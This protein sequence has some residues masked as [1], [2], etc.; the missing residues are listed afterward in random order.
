M[1]QKQIEEIET[2][3]TVEVLNIQQEIIE[4]EDRIGEGRRLE[5]RENNR[6]RRIIEGENR[7]NNNLNREQDLILL[8]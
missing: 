1:L 2:A 5:Y 6:Q 8:D 4:I 7:Q 3:T